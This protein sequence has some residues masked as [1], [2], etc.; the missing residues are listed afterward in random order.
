M[1]TTDRW[2]AVALFQDVNQAQ[3][4]VDALL[5]AGFSSDQISFAGHGTPQGLIAGLK[6]F[7]SGKAMSMGNTYDDLR[8]KGMSD[9]DARYYQ[10]EYDSGCSIVAVIEASRLQE[11]ISI[12]SSYG[13]H[14]SPRHATDYGAATQP[15][16]T[17]AEGE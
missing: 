9:Q 8:E 1:T 16:A 5:E 15:E 12:L 2:T 13:G 6:S 3:Q 11:A 17:E 10:Q 4:A 14:G 7:F